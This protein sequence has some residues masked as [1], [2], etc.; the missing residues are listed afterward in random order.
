MSEIPL[1]GR[2]SEETLPGKVERGRRQA[3]AILGQGWAIKVLSIVVLLLAWQLVA[4][5]YPPNLLPGPDRV[6]ARIVRIIV[7]ENFF[8]HAYNTIA[9]VLVGFALALVVSI[10]GGIAMGSSNRVEKFLDTYVLV[11]LTIPGLCWAVLAL[12]WFGI[13]ELA[14]VFAIFVTTS[15]MIVV[16]M[17]QGTKAI[18][19]ELLEMGKAFRTSRGSLVRE[20]I[21]PQLLPYIFAAARFGFALG[22]KVVVLSEMFGL[23]NGI[24][25]MI[26][27]SFAVFSMESVLAWTVAFT[28][29]MVVFE[30][31]ILKP[32][33]RYF[34]R[35]RPSISF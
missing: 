3:G 24:G 12:M 28:L 23:S 9:R 26:N 32:I 13:T 11:G 31:G 17:W 27:R 16:N 15:P 20:I 2:T 5:F 25:Y 1:A 22:W 10:F 35:W 18:D 7:Q 19:R 8:F 14:P 29:I 6:A 4:F 33:E 34:T 21:V 30:F